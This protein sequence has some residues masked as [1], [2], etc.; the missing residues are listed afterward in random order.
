MTTTNVNLEKWTPLVNAL[1]FTV[2]NARDAWTV[3]TESKDWDFGPYIQA[4]YVNGEIIAEITSSKFLEPALPIHSEHRM[5]F[6]GWQKPFGHDYPNWYKV[7]PH[8]VNGHEEIARLWVKTLVEIYGMKPEWRLSVAPMSI[9]FIRAWRWEMCDTRIV[10]SYRLVDRHG[11]TQAE[12]REREA[13]RSIQSTIDKDL[14]WEV[15]QLLGRGKTLKLAGTDL[16]RLAQCEA[17]PEV[18]KI[19]TQLVYAGESQLEFNV[20]SDDVQNLEL[21]REIEFDEFAGHEFLESH[22]DFDQVQSIWSGREPNGR[23]LRSV[24]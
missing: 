20:T 7:I 19:V 2:R 12:I 18:V 11:L 3:Q 14:A 1:E 9:D 4:Q 6:M 10:G 23:I 15:R 5:Q 21:Y 22:A 17:K 16:I 13:R 8:T 24:S